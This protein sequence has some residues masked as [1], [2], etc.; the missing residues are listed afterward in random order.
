MVWGVVAP[1]H[2]PLA[3]IELVVQ[4]AEALKLEGLS[5]HELDGFVNEGIIRISKHQTDNGGFSLWPG[6][7]PQ[8]YYTAYA[9]WGL[10]LARE[11]GYKVNQQKITSGLRYLR[12]AHLRGHIN[13]NYYDEKHDLGNRAFA[14][15]IRSLLGDS[16]AQAAVKLSENFT[17][18]NI[19]GQS[20]LA[21]TLAASLGAKNIK[22]KQMIAHLN[23]VIENAKDKGEL[24]G[25]KSTS[26]WYMSGPIRSTSVVLDM[27]VAID[28]DNEYI[29]YLVS[30]LMRERREKKYLSTQAHLYS[31]LALMNYARSNSLKPVKVRVHLGQKQLINQTLQGANRLVISS[32]KLAQAQKLRIRS[33][34][35]IFYQVQVQFRKRFEAIKPESQG[36]SLTRVYLDEH[37]DP[38]THFK[39]G[40]LVTV[41]LTLPIDRWINHLM[42]SDHLPAGFEALNTRFKTVDSLGDPS[43]SRR[44]SKFFRE[45]HTERVDFATEYLWKKTY[46]IEYQMRAIAEGRFTL[47]PARTELMYEPEKNAQTGVEYIEVHA[48]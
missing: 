36:L 18:M 28:P 4:L 13:A 34:H 44:K 40:D 5:G 21:R 22:V 9:L 7:D 48:K 6:G 1:D 41:Q 29:P 8:T 39:V 26:S 10:Y 2:Q 20:F 24:L 38:Q 12:T 17:A 32:H 33:D 42:V 27:L 43:T 47:P 11:A 30:R 14:L 46:T 15:Y 16:D 25:Q 35:R 3:F 23:R 19:Y 37:G 31:L 45:M